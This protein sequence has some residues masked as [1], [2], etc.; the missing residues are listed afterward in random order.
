MQT[1]QR[2]CMP[3]LELLLLSL[4]HTMGWV[5]SA[6]DGRGMFPILSIVFLSNQT[7]TTQMGKRNDG[8]PKTRT[9]FLTLSSSDHH[10]TALMF[11]WCLS[12]FW[13]QS[14]LDGCHR[15]K[16]HRKHTH[17]HINTHIHTWQRNISVNKL[18][19]AR[20]ASS[21]YWFV[22]A[23]LPTQDNCDDRD[24]TFTTI[25]HREH[26]TELNIVCLTL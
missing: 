14:L 25:D 6:G 12:V 11:L 10:L 9:N 1:P 21:H 4:L 16:L 19:G 8:G 22:S 15:K 17:S 5:G 3:F 18:A 13:W 23:T 24:V 26:V 20:T 2:F 7:T